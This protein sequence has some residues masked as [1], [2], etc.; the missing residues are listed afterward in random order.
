M[1]TF[2]C[3]LLS[4]KAFVVYHVSY[5]PRELPFKEITHRTLSFRASSSQLAFS[6]SDRFLHSFARTFKRSSLSCEWEEQHE[7][8]Q[9][10]KIWCP[11]SSLTLTMPLRA[12][13]SF[14]F[15]SEKHMNAVRGGMGTVGSFCNG[16]GAP[17]VDENLLSVVR[18]LEGGTFS[19]ERKT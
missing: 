7:I 14:F 13:M 2:V 1:W 3:C 19:E 8:H 12:I 18:K 10:P 16:E 6:L 9:Y 11:F 4:N 17:A 15:A 5:W